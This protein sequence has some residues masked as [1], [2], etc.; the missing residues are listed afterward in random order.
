MLLQGCIYDSVSGLIP[1]FYRSSK[2]INSIK[3]FCA[4]SFVHVISLWPHFLLINSDS[5]VSWKQSCLGVL[6]ALVM[7]EALLRGIR[8]QWP[9]TQAKLETSVGCILHEMS[10]SMSSVSWCQMWVRIPFQVP[11]TTQ[12]L[13]PVLGPSQWSWSNCQV[14]DVGCSMEVEGKTC[15]KAGV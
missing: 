10:F 11:S 1:S 13:N 12:N 2:F 15:Q 14:P 8:P 4:C 3:F 7:P 6:K 9:Q 5:F